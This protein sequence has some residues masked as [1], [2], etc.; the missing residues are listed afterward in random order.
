MDRQLT[1]RVYMDNAATSW[2]KSPSVLQAVQ[3]YL[4]N[5]GATAGRGSYRSAIEAENWVSRARQAVAQLIG[6]R[7][8]EVAFCTS[9]TH[10]LNAAL[11]GIIRT[12]ENVV[13]CELEHN[14]VL[15]PL[16]AMVEQGQ[17]S[18]TVASIESSGIPD[19]EV[20]A[21]QVPATTNTVVLGHA[22]N[23]TGW[24][25]DIEA[26]RIPGESQLIVDASQTIGY[27]SIDVKKLKIDVLAAAGHKGL[28]AIGGTGLIYVRKELQQD[29]LPL[30]RGGT[31]RNSHSTD[32]TPIWPESVE[33]GNLNL[34][35]VVSLAV[36]AEQLL[37]YGRLDDWRMQFT[38]LVDGLR[39]L[40]S[41]SVV[42]GLPESKD[43][44]RHVPVVSLTVDGWDVHDLAAILDSSFGIEARAGWHCAALAHRPVGTEQA[45]GTLRLSTGRYTTSEQVEQVL[46]SLASI[47]G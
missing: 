23:V 31:G 20:F 8:D 13:T 44:D 37:E 33:V 10:A 19:P 3:E 4:S 30:L 12:G 26:V 25:T 41:V 34:P 17:V 36:A 6:A 39:E 1:S 32:A 46:E 35:G 38:Q 43:L 16:W 42:G 29:F 47:V 40:P 14:S 5:C 22:S 45:G 28:G 9:G 15:R 24:A 7:P 11:H 21:Q 27:L 2:P 18:L